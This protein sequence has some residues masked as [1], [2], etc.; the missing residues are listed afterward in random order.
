M[1][2]SSGRCSQDGRAGGRGSTHRV[3]CGIPCREWRRPRD[4]SFEDDDR[5]A[6][7]E[8]AFE[9]TH[10]RQAHSRRVCP[11]SRGPE[12]IL[13]STPWSSQTGVGGLRFP[14]LHWDRLNRKRDSRS[15]PLRVPMRGSSLR[16]IGSF[17]TGT[18]RPATGCPPSASSVSDSRS[19]AARSATPSVWLEAWEWPGYVREV[20]PS[21]RT[22]RHALS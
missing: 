18:S 14:D 16:S 22:C 21:C 6:R 17:V 1:A 15:F 11:V 2:N 12:P 19:G 4:T 20:A 7:L 10:P 5:G 9:V 8:G 3:R 13:P